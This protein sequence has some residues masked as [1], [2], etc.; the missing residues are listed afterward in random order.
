[1]KK[2]LCF[3]LMVSGFAR[4]QKEIRLYDGPAPGSESWNW[5]EKQNDKN[6]AHQMTVYNVVNPSLTVFLPDPATANGTAVI[7]CPG[8]GFH[9]L[10]IDNEGTLVAKWLVK[11]GVTAFVLKYRVAHITSDDPLGDMIAGFSDPKRKDTYDAEMKSMIPLVIQDGRTAIAYVRNHASE[12][13]ISKDRIGIIGFSAGGTVTA[14]AAFNYT[15]ENRPDFVA[16]IYAYMPASLISE[17]L[18]DAPPLFL[19]CASDDQLGLASNSVD[20]YD[21]WLAAKHSV[22]MHLYARGGHGFGMSIQ[23]IPTDSWI[24]R[25]G[26]WLEFLGLL[27][28]VHK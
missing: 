24:D 6:I 5:V 25:Y 15:K 2:I 9:F 1:M 27:K 21:K 18:P 23:H 14:S 3:L 20:L 28:P 11:K 4:A 19:S 16:P 8:G 13:N 22:E 7:I 17:V 10:T 12:Y 26:E